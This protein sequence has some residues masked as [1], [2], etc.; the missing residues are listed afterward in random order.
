MFQAS[1]S[2]TDRP[3]SFKERGFDFIPIRQAHLDFLGYCYG[4]T[5]PP[6]EEVEGFALVDRNCLPLGLALVHFED[7]GT[8]TCHAHFGKWLKIY[9]KDIL[10]GM[11][12][13]MDSL[14]ERGIFILHA[15]ADDGIEG[16]DTLV[17]WC[18]GVPT[19]Q[20][21]ETGPIY[22]I[23]LRDMKV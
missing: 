23:D 6:L 5:P 9:P 14:R 17:K 22:R 4:R 20:R 2:E 13:T 3:L 8:V 10:R 7:G 18:R 1:T 19:G 12:V 21:A 11:K 16:S 15:I